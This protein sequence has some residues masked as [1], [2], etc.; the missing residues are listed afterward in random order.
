MDMTGLKLKTIDKTCS[1]LV[2]RPKKSRQIFRAQH[3][4]KSMNAQCVDRPLTTFRSE[5]AFQGH[6]S[7]VSAACLKFLQGLQMKALL[8]VHLHMQGVILNGDAACLARDAP[9]TSRMTVMALA[10]LPNNTFGSSPSSKSHISVK[11][12]SLT[13]KVQ[14]LAIGKQHFKIQQYISRILM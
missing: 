10:S 13:T 7:T 5:A 11:L 12:I 2:G 9:M 4:L 3:C 1:F 14:I 6:H 8:S